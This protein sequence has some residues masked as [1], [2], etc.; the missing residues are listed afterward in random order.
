MAGMGAFLLAASDPKSDFPAER[1][2][3]RK[4]PRNGVIAEYSRSGSLT[5]LARITPT[6]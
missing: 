3:S 1:S 4:Q 5:A 2:T 6:E